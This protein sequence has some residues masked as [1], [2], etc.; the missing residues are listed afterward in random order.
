MG[1]TYK[2]FD[3]NLHSYVAIKTIYPPLLQNRKVRERFERE[4][5]QAA[6]FR[7]ANVAS[8]YYLKTTAEHCFYAME[9]VEGESIEQLVERSGP[10]NLSFALELAAQ[11]ADAL[12]AAEKLRLVHRDIK[13]S[14]LMLTRGEDGRVQVK[15]I[16]F[17]VALWQAP[18][19]SSDAEQLT[20]AGLVGTTHFA[21]PE[22]LRREPLDSRSDI[23][24]LGA[25]L[26]FMLTGRPPFDGPPSEVID[27]H[28]HS[29]AP[30]RELTSVPPGVRELLGRMLEKDPARRPES[31]G[32]LQ[33]EIEQCR[34]KVPRTTSKTPVTKRRSKSL[35]RWIPVGGIILLVAAGAVTWHFL[36][37]KK[38]PNSPRAPGP[39]AEQTIAVLPFHPLTPDD[40]SKRVAESIQDEV[41][42]SLA[43]NKRLTV[44]SPDSANSPRL[45]SMTA[46]EKGHAL[47]AS[48]LCGG[49]VQRDRDHYRVNAQLVEAPTGKT[50]YA[51]VFDGE[52]NDLFALQR[53]IAQEMTVQL[54]PDRP[55][56]E[57]P[58]VPTENVAAYEAYLQGRDWER[59]VDNTAGMNAQ[60]ASEL[61]EQAVNL[62]STFGLAEAALGSVCARIY[63]QTDERDQ[64]QKYLTKAQRA[65]EQAVKLQPNLPEVHSAL[66][67]YYYYG[68]RDYDHALKEFRLA[69][70]ELPN[71]ADVALALGLVLRR[72]AAW[73]ESVASLQR[74]SRLDP[75]NMRVLSHLAETLDGLRRYQEE[76]QVY[77]RELALKPDDAELRLEHAYLHWK[78]TG[79]TGELRQ[80]ADEIDP[81]HESDD[82]AFAR[83]DVDMLERKFDAAVSDVQKS[84]RAEFDTGSGIM[85]KELLCALALWAK[86]DELAARPYFETSRTHLEEALTKDP[87][88]AR[89]RVTLALAYA[90]L[91]RKAEAVEQARL[92]LQER[93]PEIDPVAGP[94]IA[95][96]VARVYV[97]V[98]DKHA[99]MAEL[100]RLSK[101]AFGISTVRLKFDPAWD[102]LRQ[103]PEWQHLFK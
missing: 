73:D 59:R 40:S 64:R 2:A 50:V 39:V 16:D 103:L 11:V 101:M 9:L 18:Q 63:W 15:L 77:A 99:A 76:E 78:E 49:S 68:H 31:A 26:W 4:A 52:E 21:S 66:G 71:D 86:G 96:S 89:L 44:I 35:V 1:V 70:K 65:V 87:Q 84:P 94:P 83:W 37:A 55:Y 10:L 6:R 102:P 62:D 41:V 28:V 29:P 58:G 19:A 93:S 32:K 3:T 72:K 67:Y 95:D 20:Q 14:N 81:A 69:Q 42:A 23:Y 43:R 33:M 53:H 85:P 88:E 48:I 92:A 27:K 25:T 36:T 8:I 5:R 51:G 47:G 97:M 91:G 38:A 13:P 57:A 56:E 98:G 82:Q 74:A 22:Q 75:L 12:A 17:G 30:L 46:A 90:G 54:Q 7:H 24:S 61:Y 80:T 100:T 45:V 79:S 34:G 60:K